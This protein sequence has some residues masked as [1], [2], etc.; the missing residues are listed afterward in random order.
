MNVPPADRLIGARWIPQSA[1]RSSLRPAGV[2]AYV[3]PT[4]RDSVCS[5]GMPKHFGF[6]AEDK[7][8]ITE[9]SHFGDIKTRDFSFD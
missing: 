9:L 2:V 3:W 6:L 1:E 5:F 7:L 8:G 4:L